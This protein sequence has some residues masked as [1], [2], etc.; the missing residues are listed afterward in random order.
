MGTDIYDSVDYSVV[1]PTKKWQILKTQSRFALWGTH[2][3]PGLLGFTT[4]IH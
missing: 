2:N 1:D 3:C 4:T